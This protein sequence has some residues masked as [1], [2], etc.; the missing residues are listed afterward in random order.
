[1]LASGL[2]YAA[3][4]AVVPR[5][6]VTRAAVVQLGVPVLTALL[7][8]LLL[9]EGVT[10]RLALCTLAIVGGIGVVFWRLAKK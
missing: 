10:L 4:Y 2:G 6:G 3:W 7:G 9:H 8:V 1:M 5:L